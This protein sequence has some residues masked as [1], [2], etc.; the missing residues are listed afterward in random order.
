MAA[1]TASSRSALQLVIHPTISRPALTA[2]PPP[3]HHE[4]S[5]NNVVE[6][7][8]LLQQKHGLSHEL[9]LQIFEYAHCWRLRTTSRETAVTIRSR[10]ETYLASGAIE[11]V[12]VRPV[13]R[14]TF[15]I[16]SKDQGWSSY[17]ADHG[18]FRNSWTWFEAV[19]IRSATENNMVPPPRRI[20]TNIHAG[21]ELRTHVVTWK[22]DS[23]DS[24]EREWVT[25]LRKGDIVVVEAYAMYPGWKNHV[26]NAQIEL[27]T[28][29]F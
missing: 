29:I 26:K 4:M 22:A 17:P 13:R 18:T 27:Y 1:G 9:I 19:V 20:A 28:A 21:K 6:I 2:N 7:A 15:T 25:G 16:T 12:G 24:D 23:D 3:L 5:P 11:G 8:S 10:S 14:L